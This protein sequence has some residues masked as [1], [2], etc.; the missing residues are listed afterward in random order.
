MYKKNNRAPLA[1]VLVVNRAYSTSSIRNGVCLACKAWALRRLLLSVCDLHENEAI[2]HKG[3]NKSFSKADL[4]RQ[5][6]SSGLWET[7]TQKQV[8]FDRLSE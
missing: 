6:K 1:L 2:I 5:R 3:V 4:L 7:A 8:L